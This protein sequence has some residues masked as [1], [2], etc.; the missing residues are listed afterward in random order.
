LEPARFPSIGSPHYCGWYRHFSDHV[1]PNCDGA[2]RRAHASPHAF[3]ID[4]GVI[5]QWTNAFGALRYCKDVRN[6]YAHCNW[7]SDEGRPLTFVNLE[8]DTASPEG[9][10]NIQLYPTDLAL[11]RKQHDYFEYANDWLYFLDCRCRKVKEEKVP[12]PSVPK[13]IPQPPKHNRPKTA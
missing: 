9:T 5:G 10:L 3:R 11:L 2:E 4:Y 12:E 6:Q 7:Y 13:S 8:R 1:T